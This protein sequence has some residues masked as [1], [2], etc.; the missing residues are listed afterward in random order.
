MLIY[1]FFKIVVGYNIIYFKFKLSNWNAGFVVH[2]R[3][4]YRITPSV[5]VLDA[6][7]DFDHITQII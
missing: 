4:I 1:P 5:V 7:G 2:E 6:A 3:E